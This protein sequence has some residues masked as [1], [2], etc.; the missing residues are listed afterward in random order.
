MASWQCRWGGEAGSGGGPITFQLY[1]LCAAGKGQRKEEAEVKGKKFFSK[2]LQLQEQEQGKEIKCK[3]Q[4]EKGEVILLLASSILPF[5]E[6]LVLS[7]FTAMVVGALDYMQ[8]L[9][10]FPLAAFLKLVSLAIFPN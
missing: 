9:D 3:R 8:S 1:P 7:R 6:L 2:K 4:G 10:S 5:P